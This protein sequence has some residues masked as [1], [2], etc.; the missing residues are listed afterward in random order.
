[1][2]LVAPCSPDTCTR[3]PCHAQQKDF[4][5]LKELEK[6]GPKEK[7]VGRRH[8][9]GA[10]S[11]WRSLSVAAAHSSCS[12]GQGSARLALGRQH[13]HLR[14]DWHVQL[15]LGFSLDRARDGRLSDSGRVPL[16]SARLIRSHTCVHTCTRTTSSA[17]R[18]L[19]S[20]C[21]P[22]KRSKRNSPRRSDLLQR[23]VKDAKS[24]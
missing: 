20:S 13:A 4:F 21:P 8:N 17:R 19:R 15:L 22:V 2:R 11:Y 3:M 7:G 14:E 5:T 12:V 18:N 23:P 6:M 10:A 1:M 24:R 9:V 16:Q